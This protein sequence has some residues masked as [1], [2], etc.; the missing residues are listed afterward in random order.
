MKTIALVA[1]NG[2]GKGLF[3]DLLAKLLPGRRIVSVR[4]SD[5]LGDILDILGIE[6]SRDNIDTLVT[7]LRRG[8]D[9]EGVLVGAMRKRLQRF[10]ATDADIVVLDG[11][12]KEMEIPVVRERGGILVYVAAD[13]AVRFERLKG[14][15]EKADE[16]G[17]TW[18]QFEEQSRAAPQ[19]Q[20]R[21][22]G[23][24]MADVKIE[25]NGS[26]PELRAAVQAFI[27]TYLRD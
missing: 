22:V 25:N 14:R 11:L 4:F 12:R 27:E 10:Q 15:A 9:N 18:E 17:M 24:T 2:A 6:K 1:E 19:I 23:E 21:H 8:F 3:V 5:A 16:L 20:I 7:A 26:V 13:A